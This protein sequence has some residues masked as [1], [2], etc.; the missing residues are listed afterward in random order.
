MFAYCRNNPVKRKDA[1][2]TD[3]IC[4]T[5]NEDNNP[6][7]D[8]GPVSGSGGAGGGGYVYG[9]DFSTATY[10]S[11]YTGGIYNTGYTAYGYNTAPTS[12]GQSSNSTPSACF[13]EGTLIKA[14]SCN[15][16]IEEIEI[17]DLVWA[18]DEAA[19]DV[20]LKEVVEIYMNQSNELIHIFVNG[21]EI[22]TTP[23][24]PFY[25][26]VKG[27]TDASKLRAGDILVLLNG[28]YV[29][30]E[31]IQHEILE[32][33]I[34]VYNFQVEGYHTYYVANIGVLVHNACSK[35]VS[36]E[37]VSDSF[38]RHNNIDAHAF[39]NQAAGV[40]RS[41]LSKYDIYKDKANN[42]QLWVGTKQYTDW[43]ITNYTFKELTM[44]WTKE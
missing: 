12:S 23:T 21:E 15:V 34:T 7:N 35:P 17:G 19:G 2:G 11:L 44:V 38:I 29:V 1:S 16:P 43:R 3:D 36:P 10:S 26:P 5:S 32:T 18:W 28:E 20:A 40:P 8:M 9:V 4:V 13:V 14:N 25:S 33:P 39:K 6:F 31:K 42:N 24:H 30:V 41:M 22:V 37:K 27:W